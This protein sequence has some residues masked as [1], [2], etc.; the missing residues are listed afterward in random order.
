MFALY[1]KELSS[2]F[3]SLMGYLT[4]IV[5]LVLTGLLLWVFN[6]DFNI[7]NYGYAGLD[8]LF[9][10]G[11]FLYLF[12]IPAIT[13]RMFAEE[14]KN[15]TIEL[16]F[17]KPLSDMAI[18][19]AKFL[20]G[21]T[22]VFISLLPTLVYYFS[23]YHLGDPVGNIDTGSVIGS[24]IGLLFL[25]ATFVSIGL[26]ATSLTNNQIVAFITAALLCA[27]CYLG[28]EALYNM[29]FLGKVGLFVQGLGIQ[30]HYESISRGVIDTRDVIYFLSVI[31]IF[32]MGTRLVLQSRKWQK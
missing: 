1:K 3:S 8:G 9:F 26:F 10:V 4:I 13:M 30:A 32:M 11:P 27:F 18:I 22:L 23:V 25:G 28:F 5:F 14:K 31:T 16:L 15:G 24:Y 29:N 12:L 6:S 21:L 2:F 7:L 17:T 19:G 20:A